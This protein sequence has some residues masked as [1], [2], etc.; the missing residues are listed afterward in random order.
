MGEGE[1]GREIELVVGGGE[2]EE[3]AALPVRNSRRH[4]FDNLEIEDLMPKVKKDDEVAEEGRVSI[5]LP[6]K[7]ALLLMRCRSD[8]VKMADLT[9]RFSDSSVQDDD[10]DEEDENEKETANVK[11]FD[12]IEEGSE[13]RD[14]VDV[15]EKRVKPE[16]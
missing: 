14:S 13:K 15:S 5:C 4:V 3:E 2:E 8:P 16:A 10:D 1:K 6:P 9:N 7:N 11:E 12:V